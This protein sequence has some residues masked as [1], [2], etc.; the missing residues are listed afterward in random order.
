MGREAFGASKEGW[1]V[2]LPDVRTRSLRRGS[3]LPHVADFNA[4]VV[5]G[6]VR[7]APEG[8]ARTEISEQTG[9]TVQTVSNITRRLLSEGLLVEGGRVTGSPG[10]PRTLLRINAPGRFAIGMHVDP[11]VLTYVLLNLD[12]TV[13]AKSRVRNPS[14]ISHEELVE[15]SSSEVESLISS[16]GIERSRITG[17]GIASPGPI[18]TRLGIVVDPPHL[19]GWKRVHL[20]Q[21]LQEATGLPVILDKDVTAAAVAERWAGAA[22]ESAD[23]LFLYLGTGLGMGMVIN[24][25]VVRGSSGNAGDIGHI[26]TGQGTTVCTCGQR[27]CHGQAEC[28][29]VICSPVT[30]VSQAIE[31]GIM[32]PSPSL[33]AGEALTRFPELC[34]LASRGSAEAKAI[35]DHAA[36]RLG[37]SLSQVCNL[38]DPELVVVGGPAWTPAADHYLPRLRQSVQS[39]SVAGDIHQLRLVGTSIGD[40]VAAVGA[41]CLVLDS[42]YS[43]RPDSL[44]VS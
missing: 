34:D 22:T 10:K 30:L 35:L 31:R 32:A 37:E 38:M 9:L 20:R 23:F 16:S 12:G 17:L 29:G 41:G 2:D 18:D 5:L 19:K 27:G 14:D 40:D 28:V 4:S 11:A 25:I 3:N 15:V 8:I 42:I 1:P 21:D 39:Q 26:I 7:R 13:I 6:A 24:D 43:A 36:L 44:M 33:P